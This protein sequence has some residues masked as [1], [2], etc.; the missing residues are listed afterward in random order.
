VRLSGQGRRFGRGTLDQWN[1]SDHCR[2]IGPGRDCRPPNRRDRLRYARQLEGGGGDRG[3]SPRPVVSHRAS[4]G[5]DRAQ[6]GRSPGPRLASAPAPDPGTR[7]RCL[8][9]R[10]ARRTWPSRT[11]SRDG[12]PHHRQVRAHDRRPRQ[13]SGKTYPRTRR[14]RSTVPTRRSTTR[15]ASAPAFSCNPP[16][17]RPPCGCRT[18]GRCPPTGRSS[19]SRSSIGGYLHFEADDLDA[20]IELAFRIPAASMGG[21]IEVRPIVEW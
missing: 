2:R 12:A 8:A 10:R 14:R 20:A 11:R 18:A 6:R 4:E 17:R 1:R 15:P 9:R 7:P 5:R 16:R 19:R 3:S 13:T 21:A